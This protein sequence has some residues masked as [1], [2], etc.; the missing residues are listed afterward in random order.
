MYI[1]FNIM[2]S[3]RLNEE[4]TSHFI[5]I[6]LMNSC[7]GLCRTNRHFWLLRL[8]ML[9][10]RGRVASLIFSIKLKVCCRIYKKIQ[11]TLFNTDLDVNSALTLFQNLQFCES[12]GT[13]CQNVWNQSWPRKCFTTVQTFQ[14]VF[15]LFQ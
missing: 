5:K 6:H 14:G 15:K 4:S 12:V 8:T 10:R 11:S 3:S 2:F 9:Q 1:L 7:N 13:G